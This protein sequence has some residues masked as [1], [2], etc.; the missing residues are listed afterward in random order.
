MKILIISCYVKLV[1]SWRKFHK[2]ANRVFA[3][4]VG[5]N[6]KIK[7]CGASPLNGEIKQ[8]ASL[9]LINCS[10]KRNDNVSDLASCMVNSLIAGF[11]MKEQNQGGFSEKEM[12][13]LPARK[14]EFRLHWDLM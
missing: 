12:Q 4:C 10:A 7:S 11:Q 8:K 2:N 14:V 6:K 5:K 3:L 13:K 1:S 9:L